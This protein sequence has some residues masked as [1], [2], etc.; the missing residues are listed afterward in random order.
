MTGVD[1]L[2]IASSLDYETFKFDLK[3]HQNGN[4]DYATFCRDTTK[5]GVAKWIVSM[6]DMTCTYYD[7]LGNEVLVE[8]IPD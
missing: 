5:S 6:Q 8:K 3:N 2:M 4:T 7:I 1:P